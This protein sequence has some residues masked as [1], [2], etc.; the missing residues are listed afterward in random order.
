VAPSLMEEFRDVAC[1]FFSLSQEEK[2]E[3][4]V[5]PGMC[6]GYGRFY[7]KSDGVANWADNLILFSFGEE[8]KL[9]HPCTP[10]KPKRFRYLTHCTALCLANF[11]DRI[12]D[13][14]L[15]TLQLWSAKGS[16]RQVWQVGF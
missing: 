5:K 8:H 3:Y 12:L 1:E 7:E 16:G 15:L 4:A 11:S 2:D 14:A 13:D 10:S 6:V 9:A